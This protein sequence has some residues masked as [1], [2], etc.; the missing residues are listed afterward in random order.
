VWKTL[1]ERYRSALRYKLLVLVLLPL[2]L[3]MAAT[4]GYTLYWLNGYTLET[5]FF[6]VHD[7][8][9]LARGVLRQIGDD[10]QAPLQQLVQSPP[11]KQ[12]L[13]KSDAAAIERML[14]Q[15]RDDK[16][17]AFL[18]L[19]GVA[20]EWLY[21]PAAG[22]GRSSK[23]SPL[24]DRAARGIA[25]D[26]L[27]VFTTEDLR[28]ENVELVSRARI[29][30]DGSAPGT[31]P[32]QR[33]ALMLRV[34]QPIADEQGRVRMVLDGAVLLNHNA[35]L[36]DAIRGRVFSS[37]G[38][39][40]GAEPIVT[41]ILGEV[42]IASSTAG[43][44]AP[45]GERVSLR[46]N[47]RTQDSGS[48]W[49]RL[50]RLGGDGFISAYGPLYDVNGQWIG[51]LH[52]G[53][54]EG[55][56][57]AA[58]YQA[59]ALLLA[60][61]FAA[62]A[63]AA[64]I[65]VRGVRTIFKP[66]ERMTAVVRATQAGE[67]RRIGPVGSHDEVGELARQFDAML[68]LLQE[69]NREI[70][71]AAQ[72]LE[73]KVA[74]R[75]RELAQK[76]AELQATVSQLAQTREQLVFA[77]KLSA[78][79]QMAAGVA[80]EINNPAAVILGNLEVLAAELGEGAQPVAQEI[81]LITQ[82]VERIR[83]IVTSLIQFAHATPTER[84]VENVDV[85]HVVRDVLPLVTHVLKGKSIRLSTRLEARNIVGA[86]VFDVEQVLI[87]LIVN[88][89]NAVRRDGTIEIATADGENGGVTISVRDN[90][91]GIAPEQLKRIF[92]PFFTTDPRHGIGL[93]LSVSYGLVSRYGGHIT[94][95]SS[96]GR[97]SVFQVTLLRRPVPV[98]EVTVRTANG[99]IST[100]AATSDKEAIYG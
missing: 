46:T 40:A 53:F 99:R 62:T 9:A 87:N 85:N 18:H 59:A 41:L 13:R 94:V 69:R 1:R 97:G 90:G 77:E 88:A 80:H 45:E 4:L 24:T 32:A 36:L 25:D 61:F 98:N 56:F 15:V 74:E 39:P 49:T 68:D 37:G 64:W 29:P 96:L 79:G 12:A 84:P 55:A 35:A 95:E 44:A 6:S 10:Y 23:P 93:G 50:D 22:A 89:A 73:A 57:R 27:E 78:L 75:T 92:D 34:A 8:L 47:M 70:Q 51:A 76:N 72:A 58:H 5:L 14:R 33:D 52:V 21:E 7:D 81:E 43:I 60:L 66:V 3:A 42:R 17:F 2:L 20:G 91:P 19:T 71:R 28:R 16:G 11:F 31:P 30:A 26:A 82:Q 86:N 83:H 65:A 67:D 63:V 54:R 100:A 48:I 38:L